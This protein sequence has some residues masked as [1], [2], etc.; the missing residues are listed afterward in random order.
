MTTG[1]LAWHLL[2]SPLA[3]AVI[4]AVA[5]GAFVRPYLTAPV[6]MLDVAVVVC[7]TA[8]LLTGGILAFRVTRPASSAAQAPASSHGRTSAAL[9]RPLAAISAGAFSTTALIGAAALAGIPVMSWT[10]VGTAVAGG[11][12]AAIV[13]ARMSTRR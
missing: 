6:W 9:G 1:R 3:G 4:A 10:L 8:G 13:V 5:F 2:A 7:G 11:A 12:V